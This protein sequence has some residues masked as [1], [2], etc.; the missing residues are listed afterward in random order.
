MN[1]V[2][3]F[4][5]VLF[6]WEPVRLIQKNFQRLDLWSGSVDELAQ[7]MT[8]H[9]DWKG[10]DAG[11]VTQEELAER[12]ATRLQ[13]DEA[14]VTSLLDDIPHDLPPI[15]RSVAALHQLFDQLGP[16]LRLFYLSNMPASYATVLE[17]KHDWISRFDDGI[18]SARVGLAKPDSA[19]YHTAEERFGLTP[20]DTLFLD[21]SLPN[22]NAARARGWLAEHITTAHDVPAAL[23][24]HGAL[25]AS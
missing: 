20:A 18:F 10:F 17:E 23:R 12:T 1:I 21:D 16:D 15:E 14:D 6:A 11:W 22:I 3:D 4:G 24:K 13:I 5:N 9:E 19:I 2:F 8:G 25:Q 7:A